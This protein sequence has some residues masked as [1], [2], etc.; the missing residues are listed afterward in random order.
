MKNHCQNSVFKFK[1]RRCN[2]ALKIQQP[3]FIHTPVGRCRLNR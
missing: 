1:L 3:A 2:K